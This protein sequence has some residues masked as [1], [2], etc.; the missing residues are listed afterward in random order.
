MSIEQLQDHPPPSFEDGKS[1]GSLC[2]EFS[3]FIYQCA[4]KCRTAVPETTQ[5]S[6]DLSRWQRIIDCDDPKM[7]WRAIDW[8]GEFD[9]TP[10]KEK[11]SDEEF[12]AHIEQLL[13]PPDLD[14]GWP[15]VEHQVSIPLLDDP[16]AEKE[17]TEVIYKQMKPGKQ[18][19]LD[20]KLW[21]AQPSTCAVAPVLYFAVESCAG[22]SH[23]VIVPRK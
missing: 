4:T 6:P 9:P 10:E 5:N 16:I 11:P 7:L 20:G 21:D 19:G 14:D 8:K 23:V 22:A 18:A 17:C 15:T 13:N 1:V 12:Q 3:D 2:T